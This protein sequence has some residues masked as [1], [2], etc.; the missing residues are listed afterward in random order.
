MRLYKR[1]SN[2]QNWFQE[3][4][5]NA[6]EAC[7]TGRMGYQKAASQF[8]VP[9]STLRDRVKVA[10]ATGNNVLDVAKKGMGRFKTVFTKEQEEEL[11]S[12]LLEMETKLFGIGIAHLRKIAYD[13]AKQNDVRHNFSKNLQKAGTEWVRGFLKRHPITRS[14]ICSIARIFNCDQSKIIAERGR[15]QVGTFSTSERLKCAF[16]QLGRGAMAPGGS[17][18]GAAVLEKQNTIEYPS[19]GDEEASQYVKPTAKDPVLL[20]LGGTLPAQKNLKTI[21]LTKENNVILLCFPPHCTQRLQPFDVG[22]MALLS[23]YYGQDINVWLTSNPGRVVTQLQ[24]AKLFGSAYA[25][26]ATAMNTFAKTK[27][28]PLNENVFSDV[29]FPAS[30]V[31]ESK[32]V[33]AAR[34]NEHI[35]KD[36]Q[37]PP[38]S[39][40]VAHETVNYEEAANDGSLPG[41][42]N[43]SFTV[44]S[45]DICP[46][47]KGQR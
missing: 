40:S 28:W 15:K 32:T 3:N 44:T 9:R 46:V 33:D 13:L 34:L 8:N 35:A 25:K 45:K 31:T 29:D 39:S 7:V 23:A 1:I 38:P 36:R 18:A 17:E 11:V 41:S 20:L 21:S 12:Y 5:A 30:D 47:L 27:I 19:A 6:I 26:A 37:T 22:F 24:V 2:R 14:N 16:Q 42:S 43:S 4:M 10:I